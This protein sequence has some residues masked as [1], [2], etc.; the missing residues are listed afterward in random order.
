M[1]V[2]GADPQADGASL[3][4]DWRGPI[5]APLVAQARRLPKIGAGPAYPLVR[6]AGNLPAAARA[7]KVVALATSWFPSVTARAWLQEA[8]AESP[9]ALAAAKGERIRGAQ[10]KNWGLDGS[11]PTGG[12]PGDSLRLSASPAGLNPAFP[13]PELLGEFQWLVWVLPPS[14]QP[15]GQPLSHSNLLREDT[16]PGASRFIFDRGGPTQRR[17]HETPRVSL[18]EGAL[19]STE[20]RESQPPVPYSILPGPVHQSPGSPH[21]QGEKGPDSRARS[22]VE[23]VEARV[24]DFRDASQLAR[25][26]ARPPPG[27]LGVVDQIRVVLPRLLESAAGPWELAIPRGSHGWVLSEHPILRA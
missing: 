4:A 15:L 18:R 27:P 19:H 22:P 14:F 11:G 12:A 3:P 5:I 26:L 9:L 1:G 25:F 7:D 21:F 16:H 23:G 2:L 6:S 8:G 10:P 20:E 13:A 17:R 24:G